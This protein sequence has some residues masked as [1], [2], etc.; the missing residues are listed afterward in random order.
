MLFRSVLISALSFQSIKTYYTTYQKDDWRQATQYLSTKCFQSLRLLY[1]TFNEPSILR[2]NPAIDSQ[3]VDWW[4][5]ILAKNLDSDALAASFPGEYSEVC[6]VLNHIVGFP[7]REVQAKVIQ[8][9]LM[10]R[11]PNE[12]IVKFPGVE[13]D[14][15]D[16]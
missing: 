3:K 11:F 16:R 1:P 2:Y 7:V 5:G 4:N 14:V 6:L 12:S 15:F 13:I 10:K 8:T 9:A